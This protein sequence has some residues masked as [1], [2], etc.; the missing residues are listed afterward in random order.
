MLGGSS[1]IPGTLRSTIDRLNVLFDLFKNIFGGNNE[2]QSRE[3]SEEINQIKK[4]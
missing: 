2:I 4:L 3:I 1:E